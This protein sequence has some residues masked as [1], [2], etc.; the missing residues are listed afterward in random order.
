MTEFDDHHLDEL[1]KFAKSAFSLEDILST[2]SALKYTGAIK[3]IL[4]SE[5]DSPSENFIRF[6]ASQVYDGRL[7]QPVMEE[8]ARIVKEARS[9]FINDK[10]NERLKSA[11]VKEKPGESSQQTEDQ[12]ETPA[13]QEPQDG[14]ITTEDEL[15]GY[16]IVKAIMREIVDVKRISMRDTKSYFGILLDDNNRKPICRLRFNSSQKYLGLIENKKEEKIAI[17][18][19][20]EIYTYADR[21]K[22]VISDYE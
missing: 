10:I 1:K 8:F 15:E 6:F 9:Q 7:T 19:L 20:D 13:E 4:D 3:K 12:N 5:L 14:I 21:L 18:D 22:K 16:A 2:A 17:D 11:L